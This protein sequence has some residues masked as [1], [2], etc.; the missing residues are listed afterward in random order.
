MPVVRMQ[1]VLLYI[2]AFQVVSNDLVLH[3]HMNAKHCVEKRGH[4]SFL[5]SLQERQDMCWQDPGWHLNLPHCIPQI[6]MPQQSDASVTTCQIL[7]MC[8]SCDLPDENTSHHVTKLHKRSANWQAH[9]IGPSF[10]LP[11]SASH[12]DRHDTIPLGF[13]WRPV[14]HLV[15]HCLWPAQPP[16]ND[17][18]GFFLDALL[19]HSF[20]GLVGPSLKELLRNVIGQKSADKCVVGM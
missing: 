13:V 12:K 18:L 8:S 2:P 19:P 20:I 14:C 5:C 4:V 7:T 1:L 3:P 17:A 9:L 11:C 15:G 6:R 16:F 10:E